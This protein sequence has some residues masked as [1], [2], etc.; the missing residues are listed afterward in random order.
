MSMRARQK[1]HAALYPGWKK[2]DSPARRAKIRDGQHCVSCGM[3]EKTLVLD[4]H[5]QPDHIIYLHAAHLCPLDPQYE[6]V[7]PIDGQHL[8]AMCPACH[9]AYDAYWKPRW[10][11]VEHECQ[12]HRVL[13][14]R[15]LPSPWLTHRFLDVI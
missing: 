1:T 15:W 7:E 13:L 6:L 14:S 5:G 2:K 11:A 4:E 3:A 8:R 12:L 9:G 10:A